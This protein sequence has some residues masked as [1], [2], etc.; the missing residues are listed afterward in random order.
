MHALLSV[1]RM[2]DS[3]YPLHLR[4]SLQVTVLK[5][6]PQDP[7]P[8]VHLRHRYLQIQEQQMVLILL[9]WRLLPHPEAG[10][11]PQSSSLPHW[12]NPWPGAGHLPLP[13][14]P[15]PCNP[16]AGSG[17]AA[18]LAWSHPQSA[19]A[20]MQRKVFIT[21]PFFFQYWESNPEPYAC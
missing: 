8:Q 5:P 13:S 4:M 16:P 10:S 2:D 1:P 17:A 11:A 14:G 7:R 20:K 21:K 19:P 18:G 15:F 12:P 9:P 3:L 6:E